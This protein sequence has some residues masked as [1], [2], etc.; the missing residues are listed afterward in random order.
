LG[1]SRGGRRPPW[2]SGRLAGDYELLFAYW[3]E[4]R[5]RGREDLVEAAMLSEDD[6][7]ELRRLVEEGA[8]SALDLVEKLA[9]RVEERFDPDVAA[10]AASRL[11]LPA[12][13]GEARRILARLLASWLVEAGEAWGIL[14]LRSP[15]E[16]PPPR[17]EG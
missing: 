4:A 17:R 15:W 14:R 6:F 13:G 3:E 5:R 2:A 16:G 10:A 11:G 1:G 9:A 12:G 7:Q 8:G